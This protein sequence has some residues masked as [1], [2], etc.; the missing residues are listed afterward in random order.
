[1]LVERD[2]QFCLIRHSYG[3]RTLWMAPGGGVDWH[4]QPKDA[5]IR[6]TAEEVGITALNEVRL[7]YAY[8]HQIG[9]VDDVV[10]VYASQTD[11]DFQYVSSEID[12]IAWFPPDRL[13]ERTTDGTRQSL[14]TMLAS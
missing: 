11:Q 8:V 12:E 1:M 7:V 14:C 10:V 13:P 5:A 4:E 3:N 2:G 6:E 9:W